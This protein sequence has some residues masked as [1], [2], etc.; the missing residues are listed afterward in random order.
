MMSPR[1]APAVCVILALAL[2][3]TFIHSYVGLV[4]QDGR[5][6]DVVE[7]TLAGFTS[8]KSDRRE[9][10]GARL[11]EATDWSERRYTSGLNE[12]MLTIIRS[13][14]LKSLYH[15]PE[16]AVAYRT[17]FTRSEVQYLGPAGDIPVHVLDT[18]DPT[19]P[20]GLYVLLYGDTFVVDPIWFQIRTAGELLAGGRQQMTLFFARGERRRS[21]QGVADLP[22]AP[23]LFE[24]IEQFI[25]GQATPADL[26]PGTTPRS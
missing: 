10:W 13:Y 20:V 19:G 7:P 2:V 6:T 9:N 17:S 1:Y 11:F 8:L 25:G 14:D 24:A 26:D 4:V 18:D 15:H 23:V 16:L 22:W 12:V 21:G 3:P 5:H